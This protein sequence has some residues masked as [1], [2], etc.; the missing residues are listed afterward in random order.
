MASTRLHRCRSFATAFPSRSALNTGGTSTRRDRAGDRLS[1]PWP[2]IGKVDMAY[3]SKIAS[4]APR[5]LMPILIHFI[6]SVREPQEQP[7]KSA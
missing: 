2:A 4:F 6:R 1:H 5:T 3:R 7:V